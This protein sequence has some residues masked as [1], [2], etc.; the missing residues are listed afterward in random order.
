MHSIENMTPAAAERDAKITPT[1]ARK[2]SQKRA[3]AES[4]VDVPATKKRKTAKAT[5][6]KG[7][8]DEEAATASVKGTGGSKNTKETTAKVTTNG[9]GHKSSKRKTKEEE[10]KVEPEHTRKRTKKTT[11][12]KIETI[13]DRE[14]EAA[15]PKKSRK[16][17]KTEALEVKQESGEAGE[18]GEGG[19]AEDPPKKKRRRKT[20]EEKEAEAMPLAARTNGLRMFLGAHVSSAK[21]GLHS[22]LWPG[23]FR[24][25]CSARARLRQFGRSTQFSHQLR[26]HRVNYLDCAA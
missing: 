1:N 22:V 2:R 26:A 3:A 21:G 7:A 20:K 11:K 14:E 5:V 15:T 19:E 8:L 24:L 12:V 25:V 17:I 23:R 9:T 10:I 18:A 16:R 6:L 4:S 13:E